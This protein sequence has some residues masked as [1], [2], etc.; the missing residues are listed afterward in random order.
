MND[1]MNRLIDT[2]GGIIRDEQRRRSFQA[3]LIY[4][5]FAVI[6]FVMS[7]INV[8]T[9]QWLLLTATGSFCLL[10][11]LNF[12]LDK[13]GEKTSKVASGLFVAEVILLFSYFVVTGGTN[14]FSIIWLLLLPTVGLLFFGF[15]RGSVM[16]LTMLL[17]MLAFFLVPVPVMREKAVSIYGET[18]VT[19]FP[20]VYICSYV[21]SFLLEAVRFVTARE[22][23]EARRKYEHLYNHDAL[24][25][26][27]NRHALNERLKKL[28]SSGQYSIAAMILDIDLFKK[29]NDTY[30]HMDG[31]LVLKQ[32]VEVM[33]GLL[34]TDECIYRWGG[35]EFTVLFPRLETAFSTA[36]R[37]LHAV[38][39]HDFILSRDTI[40]VTVSIGLALS[41]DCRRT[42]DF[43][44]LML[45][46]DECLYQ[47]KNQGRNRLI[48][49]KVTLVK[50]A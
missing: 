25:G 47:A 13:R 12:W 43:E 50:N 37:I 30:G 29:V 42:E 38:R 44:H 35:E 48:T 23:N 24:T 10:C 17:I 34:E 19:R 28:Q 2:L 49:K 5:A 36:E 15:A 46:A 8:I 32:L 6:A 18:F 39:D 26:A 41:D 7:A 3:R 11:V 4:A 1:S 33:N 27:Y 20:V 45:I 31:D 14:G 22:L 16:S 40:H 9:S 21:I